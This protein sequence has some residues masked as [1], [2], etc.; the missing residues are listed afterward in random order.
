[1]KTRADIY[2]YKF[3]RFSTQKAKIS[4]GFGLIFLSPFAANV[5]C[6]ENAKGYSV[7][8]SCERSNFACVGFCLLSGT[9]KDKF[10][11]KIFLQGKQFFFENFHFVPL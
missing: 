8:N 6:G 11:G 10:S 5:S 7:K 1:M 9:E 3:P 4:I 2:G